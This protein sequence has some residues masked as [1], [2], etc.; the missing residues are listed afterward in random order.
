[1]PDGSP[2]DLFRLSNS[3]G[4]TVELITYGAIIHRLLLPDRTGNVADVVLGQDSLKNYLS[5]PNCSGAFIG[6]VANRISGASFRVG[7]NEYSLDKNY[8]EDTL[9][10]GIGNYGKMNFTG[11]IC[12]TDAGAG[13]TMTLSDSGVGGFPGTMEVSVTYTLDDANNFRLVY[14]TTPEMDT[15]ISFTNHV[16]FN[17]AGHDSGSVGGHIAQFDADFITPNDSRGMPTGEI[18]AVK[19]TDFDYTSPRPLQDGFDS[20][21]PLLVQFGGFDINYCV[22]GRDMRRFG[23]VTD[24][25]SGRSVEVFSDLPGLQ[26]YAATNLRDDCPG[27]NGAV[28]QKRHAFCLETQHYPNAVNLSQ[29]PSPIAPGGVPYRTETVY[30]FGAK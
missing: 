11:T 4:T 6:R 3:T 5:T 25:L 2:V 22:R 17:L 15:P 26:L 18:K 9:H 28:Y 13:V 21:D 29:F 12:Q 10:G 7:D 27:K 1:M 8:G 19:G 30:R 24:P 20:E 23:S 16:Y 14:E